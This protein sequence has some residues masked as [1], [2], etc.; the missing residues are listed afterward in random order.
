MTIGLVSMQFYPSVYADEVHVRI[1]KTLYFQ[2][3]NLRWGLM[4]FEWP[5]QSSEL[6]HRQ[7]GH[8]GHIA[9]VHEVDEVVQMLLATEARL[10]DDGSCAF[11]RMKSLGIMPDVKSFQ[12]AMSPS[13]REG[14][15]SSCQGLLKVC[16]PRFHALLTCMCGFR[17]SV[18]A[19]KSS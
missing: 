5:K 12:F 15:V 9:V 3:A 18:C 6:Q 17:V 11:C 13:S 14:D 8:N 19:R 4:R 1:I 10:A 16:L 2:R 7:H